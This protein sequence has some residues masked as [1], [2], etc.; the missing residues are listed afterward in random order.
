MRKMNTTE[1]KSLSKDDIPKLA[2]QLGKNDVQFLVQNLSENDEKLRYNAF[3]LL[4]FL[5]RQ[6]SLVFAY[7]S[8]FEEKLESYSYQRSSGLMLLSEN[9]RWEKNGKFKKTIKKYLTHCTDEKFIT[10]RGNSRACQ[11]T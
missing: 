10:A 11:H 7:W 4:Q 6:S 5:S 2:E 3:L 8:D 9:V 1:L